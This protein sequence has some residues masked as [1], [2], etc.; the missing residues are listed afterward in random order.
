MS[1]SLLQRMQADSQFAATEVQAVWK[2][3]AE[4]DGT[5]K[6]MHYEWAAGI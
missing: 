2:G 3:T 5:N 1:V 4:V 6:I